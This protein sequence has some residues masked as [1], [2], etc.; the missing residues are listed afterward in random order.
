[1]PWLLWCFDR[2]TWPHR[3]LVIVDSS[4]QPFHTTGR[5]DIRIVRAPH[6]TLLGKKRNMAL[7]Q[8]AGDVVTWFDD[9]DWQHP[10]KL[11]WLV[12][13]LGNDAPYAGASAGWFV[14]LKHLRCLPY[15]G[16]NG[17]VVFNSAAFRKDAVLSV[18]F[19]ENLRRASDNY[20]M[21]AVYSRYPGQAALIHRDDTFFWLCHEQNLSNP[22]RRRRFRSD[23]RI[24]KALVGAEAWGNTEQMLDGLQR[25][26]YGNRAEQPIG[27]DVKRRISFAARRFEPR[28]KAKLQFDGDRA[29]NPDL[30][31]GVS[32]IIKATT[33]DA[34]YLDTMVRH[35][36]AQAR[37]EFVE[38]MI[39]VDRPTAFK[40]KYARRPHVSSKQLSVVLDQLLADGVIDRI[41]EMDTTPS[42]VQ[43]IKD[44]FFSSDA[45]RVRN[46]AASG[47]PIYPTLY[48]LESA[49][50]D[51]VLQMDADVFFYADTGVSW[52]EHALHIMNDDPHIWLMMT[53]PGPPAGPPG[54]SLG[55]RNARRAIW[56]AN[57]MLWLFR[58]ATARYFLCD[59]RKLHHRLRYVPMAQGCAPLEQCI[60]RALQEHGA[61]RGALGDLRTWHLHAWDHSEPFP[62]WVAAIARSVESGRVPVLQRGD[63][64]LRLDNPSSRKKWAELLAM[65][66]S[67]VSSNA[68]SRYGLQFVPDREARETFPSNATGHTSTYIEPAVGT[69]SDIGMPVFWGKSLASHADTAPISVVI[70]VRDRS[71][72]RVR[73]ALRSLQ[74]QTVGQ[75]LQTFIVSHGSRPDINQQLSTICEN[76]GATLVKI[77]NSAEPWNKPLALNVGLRTTA[78]HI[79][80]VMTMDVDMIL[81]PNFLTVVLG[82]LVRMPPTLVLCRISDLPT[83]ALIPTARDGLKRAFKNLQVSCRLR[84][85]YGSGGIQAA[86]RSFFFDIRG[87]DEDLLWWGAMDGDMVNRAHLAGLEIAWIEEQTSMLHQW[88]QRKHTILSNRR[89]IR[90]AS[91]AWRHNHLLVR[92]R[93]HILV[94]NP[95]GWG[96]ICE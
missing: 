79:P 91:T 42:V 54:K 20:W 61:F 48:S 71:G 14:D 63:Y 57:L 86:H 33:L 68:K 81:A 65:V 16:R 49:S 87:Y 94:R 4:P 69:K 90:Q 43:E 8:A 17:K 40:G 25:R 84:P 95:Q 74:W 32:L 1:M 55:N 44:R 15:R 59:R 36:I 45:S 77:G 70:P 64:D 28:P 72:G 34:P 31:P 5:E 51:L 76:E 92:S 11:A 10:E 85:R 30:T 27:G 60:S 73:N 41:Q 18:R 80:F 47:G 22:A 21:R 88:H 38:R 7:A 12:A 29:H 35:M 3:E 26:L 58:H 39:V 83:H 78:S 9:D 50:T 24:F 96:G 67:A 19:R 93:S 37:Y 13:A 56:D 6:G 75:P 66:E 2:Q 53:H 23:L 62:Q 89:D 46:Y 82:R 52:V